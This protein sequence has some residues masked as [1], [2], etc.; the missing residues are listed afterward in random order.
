MSSNLA[1]RLLEAIRTST[2]TQN[3]LRHIYAIRK[4]FP[5]KKNINKFIVGGA[6]EESLSRLIRKCGWECQN[7]SSTESVID[8][9]VKEGDASF[10][11]SLKSIQKLGSAVI[12]ENY[13]GQ[14]HAI[15]D[16]A[17]TILVV[18]EDDVATFAYVDQSTIADIP[19]ETVYAHSDSN[20]SMRGG[21]VRK[22][23]TSNL[24]RDMVVEIQA[25][26]VPDLPERDI[27]V[28]ALDCVEAMLRV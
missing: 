12:L 14:Q 22:L 1:I 26:S 3:A 19:H 2:E 15:G 13:R 18:L 28:L 24:Q 16:L 5:P 4:V 11:F 10:P 9:V 21:F 27:S 20:L 8:I 23:V 25:P 17:P 7:V 6:V